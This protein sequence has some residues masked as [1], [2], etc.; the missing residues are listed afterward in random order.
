MDSTNPENTSLHRKFQRKKVV[1]VDEDSAGGQQEIEITEDK[2]LKEPETNTAKCHWEA[3]YPNVKGITQTEEPQT[4]LENKVKE[5][6]IRPT[7][8]NKHNKFFHKKNQDKDFNIS[9]DI[10]V[11]NQ[12]KTGYN[13][14]QLTTERFMELMKGTSSSKIEPKRD[15]NEE[16]S[17]DKPIQPTAE[18][19]LEKQIKEKLESKTKRFKIAKTTIKRPEQH[20]NDTTN[21]VKTIIRAPEKVIDESQRAPPKTKSIIDKLLSGELTS[22]T[23]IKAKPK[24]E[25]T[26]QVLKKKPVVNKIEEKLNV[27]KDDNI[28]IKKKRTDFSF[29]DSPNDSNTTNFAFSLSKSTLNVEEVSPQKKFVIPF[30]AQPS[31]QIPQPTE[32]K[33]EKMQQQQNNTNPKAINLLKGKT[34]AKTSSLYYDDGDDVLAD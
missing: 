26:E 11:K 23:H 28:V 12:S 24:K 34:F 27:D 8:E 33:K 29:L 5:K 7:K 22:K 31:E 6:S 1:E 16:K 15:I 30:T 10:D 3:L 9:K 20:S 18:E 32:Q 4:I 2:K 13:T 19:I 25:H 17:K 14:P 21:V